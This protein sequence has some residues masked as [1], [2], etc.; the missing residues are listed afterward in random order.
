MEKIKAT[1]WN[2]ESLGRQVWR[3]IFKDKFERKDWKWGIVGVQAW[4]CKR[5]GGFGE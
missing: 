2:L 5:A 4:M 1:I 3:C